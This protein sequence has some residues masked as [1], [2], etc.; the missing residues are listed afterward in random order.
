[1]L[2]IRQI[3]ENMRTEFPSIQITSSNWDVLTELLSQLS[4]EHQILFAASICER[5]LPIY[6][7]IDFPENFN[8]K[9]LPILRE[10]LN[11]IW[12][13][14]G[15]GVFERERLQDFISVCRKNNSE[16]ETRELCCS[17]ESIA[18][19]SILSTLEFCLTKELK[20]LE[21]VFSGGHGMLWQLL[22]YSMEQE[23][24]VTGEEDIWSKK[25]REEQYSCIDND[26]YMK[27]ELQKEKDDWQILVNNPRLTAEFIQ[28][29]RHASNPDGYGMIEFEE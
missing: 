2:I 19:Y 15:M 8:H 25:S 1:M 18:P 6:T 21:E 16:I 27:R 11:Y 7:S 20:Y 10:V 5:I 24:E 13:F 17:V 3:R 9:T 22:D 23:A 4:L 14:P 29:F 28:Q 26:H 12:D